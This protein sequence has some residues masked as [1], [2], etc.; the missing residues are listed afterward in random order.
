MHQ[1]LS[2]IFAGLTVLQGSLALLGYDLLVL[3]HLDVGLVFEEFAGVGFVE[4]ADY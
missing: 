4:E 2:V 3:A 1:W